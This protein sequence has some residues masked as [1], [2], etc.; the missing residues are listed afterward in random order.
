MSTRHRRRGFTLIELLVVIAIIG[1]LVGLL[2]QAVNAA[3]ESGR[4]T[5]CM[6]N[7]R[8]LGLG[9]TGYLNAKNGV[10]PN[11]VTYGAPPAPTAN[12]APAINYEANNM[13]IIEAAGWPVRLKG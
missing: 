1:V 8:Q 12:G 7:Q 6:N 3:R 9:I 11:A 5:Q 13:A 10:F 2:L 4:R